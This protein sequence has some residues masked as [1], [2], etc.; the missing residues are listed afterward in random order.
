[1]LAL[2]SCS[3]G[4]VRDTS[5]FEMSAFLVNVGRGSMQNLEHVHALPHMRRGRYQEDSEGGGEVG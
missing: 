1:M 4:Q 2:R 5:K 3:A